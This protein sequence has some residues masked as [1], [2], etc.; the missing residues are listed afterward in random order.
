[1]RIAGLS[2]VFAA[3]PSERKI[4]FTFFFAK[5]FGRVATEWLNI[6]HDNMLTKIV[7]SIRA[8]VSL[9]MNIVRKKNLNLT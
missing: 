6:D 9:N 8:F 1:M 3:H 7:A 2:M 5:A 4:E